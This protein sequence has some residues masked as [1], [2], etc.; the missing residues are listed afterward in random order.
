MRPQKTIG[1]FNGDGVK[2]PTNLLTYGKIV[3]W[4]AVRR[5][6]AL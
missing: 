5:Y 4:N 6:A 1:L 3:G 2:K